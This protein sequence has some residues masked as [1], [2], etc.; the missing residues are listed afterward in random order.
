[1]VS[2]EQALSCF[3]EVRRLVV[4]L[5]FKRSP[6]PDCC[7]DWTD[8]H[9]DVIRAHGL[10]PW[11][12]RS[13]AE[14]PEAGLPLKLKRVFQH[15]YML[16]RIASMT[17]E[18]A[19][20]QILEAFN[21]KGISPVLLKGA[22]LGALVY[23]DPALRTMCDMDLLV[24]EEDFE[25]AG[26]ILTSLGYVI[27]FESACPEDRILQPG[28]TFTRMGDRLTTVDL[29]RSLRSMDFYRFLSIQVL[30]QTIQNLLYGRRVRF[31]TP[32]MNFIYVAM[33]A[34]NHGPLLRDWLDLVLILNRTAF[35]WN[36]FI[37]L[38]KALG[39]LRPMWWVFQEMSTEWE[40]V[41]PLEVDNVLAAYHPHWLEDHV[42]SGR[43]RYLWL[44]YARIRLLNGWS[45]RIRYL[46]SRLFPPKAYREAI[47]GTDKWM[48]YFGSKLGYFLHLRT[49][50]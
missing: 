15:D 13:L 49:R 42:I 19:L 8:S 44:F 6:E 9:G 18:S 43:W 31:L 41:P 28:E 14:F 22:Y 39:A 2:G 34:L 35:D 4:A 30:Q 48:T 50:K 23:D 27:E 12:Y 25:L 38:A 32:E 26:N 45:T 20:K 1:M 3:D 36:R 11:L 21:N 5:A 47:I 33:H 46:R 10:A 7:K 17:R 37:S 24:P 29:H 16:S 40:S